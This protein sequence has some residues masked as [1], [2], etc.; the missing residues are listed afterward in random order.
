MKERLLINKRKFKIGIFDSGLGGL[1]I[2]GELQRKM[3]EYNYIYLADTL[4]SPYGNKS[5]DFLFK[6]V[7]DIVNF[8]VKQN[9]I[10]II[11][12]CNT[13]STKALK[14]IQD[15]LLEKKSPVKVLGVLIPTV[16]AITEKLKDKFGK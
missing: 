5:Q 12:A 16:E 10:L 9:C 7:T 14:K 11:V 3:P 6:R 4:Y 1:T 2:L 13:A 8:F 15:E